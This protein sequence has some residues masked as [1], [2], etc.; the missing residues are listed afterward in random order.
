MGALADGLILQEGESFYVV[1]EV[2]NFIGHVFALRSSGFTIRT[3]PLVPGIVRDGDVIGV[4]LN[5]WPRIDALPANW[6]G[7]GFERPALGEDSYK[8]GK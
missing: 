5:Y 3:E 8:E 7:F 6:D 1:L 2:T 4:D